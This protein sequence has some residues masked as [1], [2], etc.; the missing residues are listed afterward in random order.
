MGPLG[1]ALIQGAASVAGSALMNSGGGYSRRDHREQLKQQVNYERRMQRNRYKWM[2]Q[3]AEEAGFNP[4]TVLG[5]GGASSAGAL[6]YQHVSQPLGAK[7]ALGAGLMAAA[8]SYLSYDPV[9]EESRR[10][11]NEL[12]KQALEA[13]QNK[14]TRLGT[15]VPQVRTTTSETETIG[16]S[17]EI[18]E[19]G[20]MTVSNPEPRGSNRYVNP[21]LPDADTH[22][23]RYGEIGELIG[24]AKNSALDALYNKQ[25][26]GL[27]EQYGKS[28]ADAVHYRFG[29][30][31]G[32]WRDIV[33][34]EKARRGLTGKRGFPLQLEIY[35]P[36]AN[37]NGT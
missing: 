13:G 23:G 19:A 2:V 33:K 6:P 5:S 35:D 24:G 9:Y 26:Q 15:G 4:L 14:S 27:V 20:R 18:P 32:Q 36:S 30:E 1:A 16:G 8:D 29:T 25:Q 3:G 17:D 7:A 10:L 34:D 12:K 11:D 22:S 21:R 28:F 31:K 37:R